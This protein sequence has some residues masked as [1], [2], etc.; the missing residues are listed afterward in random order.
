MSKNI[1]DI[2]HDRKTV[3]II[4]ILIVAKES[5]AAKCSPYITLSKF[6]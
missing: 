1:D 3:K 6:D 2:C 5:S 4:R